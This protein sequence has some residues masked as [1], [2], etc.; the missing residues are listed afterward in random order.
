MERVFII[1]HADKAVLKISGIQVK[2]LDTRQ[3]EALLSA[4]LETMVRVIGVTG[5]QVEMDVYN[6]AP[7]QV[8]YRRNAIIEAISLIEGIT[9]TEIIEMS[10]SERIVEVDGGNVPQRADCPAERWM[11][12]R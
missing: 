11:S 9:A 12:L 3:L 8:R 5:D 6:I 10:C 2:G 1:A 4:S 7:E